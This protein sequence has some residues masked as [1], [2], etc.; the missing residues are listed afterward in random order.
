M[1]KRFRSRNGEDIRVALTNGHVAV[2][3]SEWSP[4]I[5]LLWEAAYASGCVSEDM[6]VH[7]ELD[8]VKESGMLDEVEKL[9]A[10]KGKVKDA[11][12]TAIKDNNIK[13]F[14]KNNGPTAKYLTE[15]VGEKI[16]TH[17]KNAVWEEVLDEGMSPY[18][19][20]E[21]ILKNDIT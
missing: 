8:R 16:P 13:A 17:I 6:E 3:T 19:D 14:T 15:A 11:I 1:N 2:I 21:D 18:L 7:K 5:P 20:D 12:V 4:V 10:L 9:A